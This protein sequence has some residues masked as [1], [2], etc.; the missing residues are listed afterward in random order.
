MA[1]VI[2]DASAQSCV[3]DIL[4]IDMSEIGAPKIGDGKLA[5]NVIEN[6]RCALDRIISLNHAGRL[7]AREREGIDILF[8]RHAILETQ[9]DGDGKVVHK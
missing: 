7:K 9:A 6:G 5:E 1:P 4:R 3:A 2:G 8:E